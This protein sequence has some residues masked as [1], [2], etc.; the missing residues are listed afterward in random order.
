MRAKAD[1]EAGLRASGLN[2]TILRPALFME[3]WISMI[4]GTQLQRG[5]KVVVLGDPDL[6][7]PFVGASNVADLAIAVLGDADA[8]RTSL[9]LSSQAASYRQ[10]VDWIAEAT[11]NPI[12]IDSAPI[13][14]KIPGLPAVVT[15]LWSWLAR[16]DLEPIE[17]VEV[18]IKYGLA[19][20]SPRAFIARTFGQP[21]VSV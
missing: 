13:G 2:Y 12:T 20:E 7:L 10:V 3:A 19:L 6:R 11:G 1:T 4:L 15:D 5:P 8:E 9:S 14:T 21:S 18:A 17:T 16:G